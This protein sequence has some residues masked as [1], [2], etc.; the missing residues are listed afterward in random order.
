[1]EPWVSRP[2][3]ACESRAVTSDSPAWRQ[4][5]FRLLF[6]GLY[7]P[8]KL[9]YPL[10][11]EDAAKEFDTIVLAKA[12]D[13]YTWSGNESNAQ[14]TRDQFMRNSNSTPV[15]LLRAWAVRAPLRQRPVR[16]FYKP[17]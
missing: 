9:R 7:G 10:F 11:G 16:D 4:H 5:S 8:T 12:N 13:G 2:T 6:K 14:Y 3:A 17:L 15:T 1:M